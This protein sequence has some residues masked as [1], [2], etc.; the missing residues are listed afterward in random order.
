MAKTAELDEELL[1]SGEQST[2][3]GDDAPSDEDL[4]PEGK[5]VCAIT[6]EQRVATPQEETFQ[7]FAEQLHREYGIPLEDMGRDVKVPCVYED[8][9]SGKE[10]SRSRTVSLVVYDHGAER[11]VVN[12]IRVGVVAKP[13]VKPGPQAL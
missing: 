3:A 13:G 7:S 4:I 2:A 6:G 11:D 8:P 1:R 9:K 5:L 10:K 12:I